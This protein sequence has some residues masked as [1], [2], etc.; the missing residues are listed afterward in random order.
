MWVSCSNSQTPM[1]NS[2][3]EA[4]REKY[5][6]SQSCSQSRALTRGEGTG[7]VN[8]LWDGPLALPPPWTS[9]TAVPLHLLHKPHAKLGGKGSCMWRW[10]WHLE[11]IP[12]FSCSSVGKESAC[13]AE[14]PGSIP[15]LGRF[16]GE[17]NGNPLQ[18]S[19]LENPM[20][21]GAWEATVHGVPRVGMTEWLNHHHQ[22]FKEPLQRQ[23]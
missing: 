15:G 16:P 9:E 23:A 12:S 18:Y 10:M 4:G 17:K 6:G 5:A 22:V 2:R 19:C 11:Q 8:S 1:R 3:E 14:D 13:S 7:W 21:R 20:N